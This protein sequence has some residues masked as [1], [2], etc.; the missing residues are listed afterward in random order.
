LKKT[1][2]K[3]V[4]IATSAL[5]LY[6]FTQLFFMSDSFVKDMGLEPSVTTLVLGRRA[7]MFMLGVAVLMFAAR[8]LLPSPARR[9][10][11]SATGI[12]L[13]GLSCLGTYEFIQGRVNNSIWIAV[14]IE[15]VLW[16]SYG[17][18][19]LKDMRIQSFDKT[20]SP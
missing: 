6:L 4:S 16:I 3:I 2:Y 1:F 12:T 7:A 11:C 5:F 17:I 9:M 13:F 10:I 18:I 8:N 14:S 20:V 19:V 15:S